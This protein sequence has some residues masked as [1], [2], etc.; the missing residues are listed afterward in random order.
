MM[1][2]DAAVDIFCGR[3]ARAQTVGVLCGFGSRA[4]LERYGADLILA[5]TVELEGALDGGSIEN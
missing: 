4:E 3:S 2:G 1:V 5:H